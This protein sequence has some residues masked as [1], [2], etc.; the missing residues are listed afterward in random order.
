MQE[1]HEKMLVGKLPYYRMRKLLL[2][3]FAIIKLNLTSA[4]DNRV[5]FQQAFFRVIPAQAYFTEC[6]IVNSIT[7]LNL[8]A[9]SKYGA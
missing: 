2:G 8:K 9:S 3:F 1:L 5:H 7:K 6:Q 4:F